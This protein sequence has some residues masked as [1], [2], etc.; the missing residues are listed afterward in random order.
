MENKEKP[1]SRGHGKMNM[2]MM[3][4]ALHTV[5]QQYSERKIN[6]GFHKIQKLTLSSE[7]QTVQL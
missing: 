2:F 5:D 6:I 7:K 3:E 1:I 4:M